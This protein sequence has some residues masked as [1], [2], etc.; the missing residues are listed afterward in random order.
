[1]RANALCPCS[2]SGIEEAEPSMIAVRDQVW[3]GRSHHACMVKH[4][5][6]GVGAHQL[7]F[8]CGS[9]FRSAAKTF[10]CL[11]YLQLSANMLTRA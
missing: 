3:D 2:T 5:C 11:A 6:A 10:Q 8:P 9:F 1:M 7:A 4:E